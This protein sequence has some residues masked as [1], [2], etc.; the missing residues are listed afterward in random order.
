MIVF[1]EPKPIASFVVDGSAESA[2]ISVQSVGGAWL[3]DVS[4]GGVESASSLDAWEVQV[5][6][7]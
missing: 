6:L 4:I 3:L 7:G 5:I 1:G 2:A